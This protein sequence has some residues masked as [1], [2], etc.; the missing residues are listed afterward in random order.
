VVEM[1]KKGFIGLWEDIFK[2]FMVGFIFGIILMILIV[3]QVIP[4]PISFCG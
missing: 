4:F 3:L 1:N 2:G